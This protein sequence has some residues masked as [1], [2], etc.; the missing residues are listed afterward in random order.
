MQVAN[1]EHKSLLVL[2]CSQRKRA[3][4]GLLPATERYDGPAFRVL[5][6]AIACEV[7]TRPDAYVLS[8]QFGLIPGDHR[9]PYYDKRMTVALARALHSEVMRGLGELLGA[10]SYKEAFICAGRTYRAALDGYGSIVPPGVTIRMAS[11]PLGRQLSEL[12]DWLHGHPPDRCL[13]SAHKPGHRVIKLRGVGIA[14]SASQIMDVA[15]AKVGQGGD[16]ADEYQSW[17]VLVDG[18]RVAPKWLV[19]QIAGLPVSRFSTDEARRV[20]GQLGIE[21]KRA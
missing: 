6:R 21:V 9:V 18:V 8:A 5:R 2:A 20:L 14:A 16:G 1:S 10:G 15:R 17:Y 13:M 4:V 12:H 19:S 3:D 7:L 11:G